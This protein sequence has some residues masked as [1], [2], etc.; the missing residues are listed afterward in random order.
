M[1]KRPPRNAL[2][3]AGLALLALLVL[4]SVEIKPIASQS[5]RFAGEASLPMEASQPL[6][7]KSAPSVEQ[8]VRELEDA[9]VVA[10]FKRLKS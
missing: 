4:I 10:S 6:P 1:D 3:D 5:I 7:A 9:P 8:C 2:R